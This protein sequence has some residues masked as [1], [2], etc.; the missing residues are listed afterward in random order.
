MG[1]NCG[2]QERH[3]QS[4][5]PVVSRA[6]VTKIPTE[7][8]EDTGKV[9][10]IKGTG[11]VGT[12]HKERSGRGD[13]AT[14][15]Y[16]NYIH[17]SR[18][19]RWLPSEGR[20]ESWEE[21]VERYIGFF[22]KRAHEQLWDVSEEE[23][24]EVSNAIL[25][26]DIMPSMRALMTAGP[27]LERDHTCAYNCAFVAVDRTFKFSEIMHALMCGTGVGFSVE[28]QFVGELPDIPEELYE[29][30]TTLYVDDSKDGWCRGFKE[31]VGL[32]YSGQIPKWDLSKIRPAG[33]RLKTFGGRASGPDPLDD[34]FC[35]CVEAFKKATGRKLTSLEV[36][37]I[38]C[39]IAEIVVVG[40]VRRSALISLSNL[41]DLRMRDAK[42]G[43]YWEYDPQRS[44]SNNSVCYTEKPDEA[45]FMQE[46]KALMESGTG[47][48][49]IFSREAARRHI[50]SNT[51]RDDSFD[52]GTNPC[53]EILL[54]DRQFCNLSEVVIR[55]NDTVES[56]AE[57]VRLATIVG[58]MQSTLTD[59]KFLSRKWKQNCEEERLLGVSLTGI[60]DHALFSSEG[61]LG[62]PLA[63]QGL[64]EKAIET[65]E[66]WAKKCNISPSTAI[67]CVKPSGTVSQ[68]VDSSSGIHPR[69]SEH[70]LRAVRND[71]KDPLS[72]F[73]IDEGIPWEEEHHQ[74]TQL[75]FYFPTKAPKDART[76]K[77]VSALEQLELWKV[78]AEHWCEHKPSITVYIKEGEWLKVGAWVYENFHLM[79]GVAF[80]PYNDHVYKQA[81]Y[82]K[83]SE[84]DYEERTKNFPKIAWSK[85]I[86]YETEDNTTASRELACTGGVCDI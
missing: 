12:V 57:K 37:D 59:F 7:S 1:A 69:F 32:L 28:R 82:Q 45:I 8:N 70:Y 19:A 62:L 73:L 25:D 38:V 44:L 10:P 9:R 29:T 61:S 54:R 64:K 80:L 2:T 23:W 21:T 76:V 27:A 55:A 46:W 18:Y 81:P 60:M 40:G 39:K 42:Q 77:D 86:G 26:M 68:L 14:S 71:K 85:F 31:L 74:E 34:L 65:N 56:V 41:S 84:E 63:L 83:L 35:W 43:K 48:R 79:S 49:G 20:R 47:E 30:S 6:T 53:S 5:E 11:T 51:R 16:R 78:Y 3:A 22:R 36:H 58:T 24:V 50:A 67:T 72:Q 13:L 4:K 75:V 33:T 15:C 66:R 52:F 17:Q